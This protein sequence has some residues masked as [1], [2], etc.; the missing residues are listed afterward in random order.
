MTRQHDPQP[1]AHILLRMIRGYDRVT[2]WVDIGARWFIGLA[3]GGMFTMLVTQVLVR[4]VPSFPVPW[5]EEAAT[6]LSGYVALVGAAVCVRA[7][8]HLQVDLLRDRLG[9]QM[10][11][12]LVILQQLLV[13]GF[14]LFLLRYGIKFVQLGWGKP[15]HSATLWCRMRAWQCPWVACC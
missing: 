10:Q 14:A 7:G 1:P 5:L 9:P 13:V 6:Y 3:L 8:F 2:G 11:Y 4:Y 12:A 15:A